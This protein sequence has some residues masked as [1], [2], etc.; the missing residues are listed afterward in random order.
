MQKNQGGRAPL[1]P[2]LDSYYLLISKFWKMELSPA[3]SASSNRLFPRCCQNFPEISPGFVF[4]P[5]FFPR[6]VIFFEIQIFT[7][8]STKGIKKG[9]KLG[10]EAIYV[11]KTA[12]IALGH[13]D[14]NLI[15]C[16]VR[17]PDEDPELSVHEYGDTMARPRGNGRTKRRPKKP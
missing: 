15:A 10:S 14:T 6:R 16:A 3:F 5:A 9:R 13:T 8:V 11:S 2:L 7:V 4:F 17:I 12:P 1:F